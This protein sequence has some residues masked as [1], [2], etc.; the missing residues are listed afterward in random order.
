[1]AVGKELHGLVRTQKRT[2]ILILILPFA[3]W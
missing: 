1:M 2:K 3:W